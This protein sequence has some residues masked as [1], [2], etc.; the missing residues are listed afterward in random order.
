M[1]T[2]ATQRFSLS[3]RVAS[4]KRETRYLNTDLDLEA[5]Q[6][7]EPL[8]AVLEAKGVFPLHVKQWDDGLWRT[9]LETEKEFS[10]PE[11]NIAAMLTAI[12]TLDPPLREVWAACTVRE[13]NIG[14]DCGD[15]PWAFNQAVTAAT[16]AAWLI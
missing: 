15:V 3:I 7:L 6:N 10:D 5:P 11:S 2:R 4:V 14:Y 16:L 8:A 1:S 12:E 13:F 9:T